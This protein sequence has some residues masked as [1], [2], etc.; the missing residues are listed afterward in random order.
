MATLL[1]AQRGSLRYDNFQFLETK[2]PWLSL[3]GIRVRPVAPVGSTSSKPVVESSLLHRTLPDELIQEVFMRLTPYS[4]GRAACVCR[5]WRYST[6]MPCLWRNACLKTWQVSG[7]EENERLCAE[8]YGSSW[9]AMWHSRPRLRY[10]GLYVSRNT[11]IRAGIAEWK[12]TNPVHLVCYY[13]YLRFYPNGKFLYKTSPLRVKE[14]AKSMQGRAT[15]SEGL[16]SGRCTLEGAQVEGAVLYPGSQPTV[17]K[18]RLRLRGTIPGAYNRLDLL[19]LVTSGVDEN[20]VASGSEDVIIDGWQDD[21]T[22][23]P[24][25]PAISHRRGMQPFVFIPFE[26]VDTSVLNLPVEKMDYYVPG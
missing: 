23:N 4:L 12:I 17:L 5:K 11:Y 20:D 25:I 18:I 3:Y 6:R 26:E 15:K 13:R 8:T 24:D 1:P 16:F 22:H 9:R 14:V 19:S 2:R 10:D 21:E 7:R